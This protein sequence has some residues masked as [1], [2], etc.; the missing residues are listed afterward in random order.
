MSNNRFGIGTVTPTANLQVAGDA[1]FNTNVTVGLSSASLNRFHVQSG[2]TA[3]V[4]NQ[5]GN[6]GIGVSNPTSSLHVMGTIN[7]SSFSTAYIAVGQVSTSTILTGTISVGEISATT[8]FASNIS[9]LTQV[10]TATVFAGDGIIN[11]LSANT[12]SING[13][14]SVSS[15]V[16]ILG[17]LSLFSDV[18]IN[19]NLIL[20][21]NV[22]TDMNSERLDITNNGTGPAFKVNQIGSEPVVVI[23]QN[24][25][26]VLTIN[27]SGETIVSGN[28]SISG[29]I[30]A[31]TLIA[32]N[33][34]GLTKISAATVFAGNASISGT[35]STGTLI[36]TNISGLT[37]ISAATVF[38]GNASISGTISA[39]T[40]IAS[41]ISGLTR[42][43]TATVFAGN[44]SVSGTISTGTLI[45]SN[46][47]GLT[48]VSTATV[49][50]GTI[51]AGTLIASNISGLTQVSTAT[52]FAGTISAGTLIASNIS[53][54]TR[55][56]ATTVFAGNIS[57]SGNSNM[58]AGTLFVDGSAGNV[59]IGTT[60]PTA[61]LHVEV[62]ALS[63]GGIDTA[64]QTVLKLIWKEGVQ[65]LG[66]GEGTK[67]ALSHI[68][69]D[70]TEYEG[71]HIASFK[72]VGADDA[73]SSTSLVFSTRANT[74]AGFNATE[75]LRIT[76]S[77]NIGI[78]TSTPTAPLNIEVPAL[79]SGGATT[80]P[81]T[82]LELRW[83]EGSTQDLGIGE[84]TKIKMSFFDDSD[85]QT[86][87]GAYITTYKE[88][89]S[90]DNSSTSLIFGTRANADPGFDATEKLRVTS[91]GN[92]GIGTSNPS[93]VLHIFS[94]VTGQDTN[95]LVES[96]NVATLTLKGDRNNTNIATVEQ[97]GALINL[98][99][100]GG[101]GYRFVVSTVQT[102]NTIAD[103]TSFTGTSSNSM[104]FGSLSSG[105]RLHF[106]VNSNVNMTIVDT[107][108]VGIGTVT[109]T[110]PLHVNVPAVSTGG[111]A[112]TPQTALKLMWKEGD[113]NLGTGEGT[114]IALSHKLFDD[115]EYEGAYIASFK[116]DSGDTDSSTSLVF[117]TRL[118]DANAT[119][120]ATERLRITSTGRV[121]IGSTTPT[122]GLLVV[123]G[124][125]SQANLTGYY[126]NSTTTITS[127]T[128]TTPSVSIYGL[129]YIWAATGFVASSDRRI[130]KDIVEI[131]DDV[132]LQAVRRLKPSMYKYVDTVSRTEEQVYGF[133]AQEVQEVLPYA[134]T[135]RTETIPDI[136]KVGILSDGGLLKLSEDCIININ[137]K[138][139]ILTKDG[140]E[141]FGTVTSVADSQNIIID[142]QID[143]FDLTE[144]QEV[145]VYGREVNDFHVL[146]KEA[147]FTV[148][149]SA[150]QELDR[151]QQLHKNKL[152]EMQTEISYQNLQIQG[153]QN[154]NAQLKA[155]LEAVL[156]HLNLT[157]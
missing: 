124:T 105:T 120:T 151:Q 11:N 35:I 115:S 81:Q 64:P 8:I 149:V 23:Q 47:S 29:T 2:S 54:L 72:E 102:A 45:A 79:S 114:K 132:A 100:D 5:N 155:K 28:V 50:A 24:T 84:G 135:E 55:I 76:S 147:V 112:T 103:G 138:L 145:F 77:G 91:S 96:A 85:Q 83:R 49:F 86:Y 144:P 140:K 113:Q 95:L 99:Q 13:G 97:G 156:A 153:L 67:I 131:N 150:I 143:N 48:Q 82:L 39:G 7:A 117:G 152:Q 89:A 16:D 32:S 75:R 68:L 110:A 63:T 71:A 90:D 69:V 14:L 148:G 19:G 122:Q 118:D 15:N 129:G 33:I 73:N 31:G 6:V 60:T 93:A 139:R 104:L 92:V 9:G 108:N 38:A 123:N 57:V 137:D 66:T 10:S 34:S 18:T 41:N 157:I 154:E 106:G 27:S 61:P 130:K 22:T 119:V 53:G 20:K 42:I 58:G 46:I 43:S 70:N 127:G 128:V 1:V 26:N 121:G 142:V 36:A 133:I 125:I 44:V 88:S 98:T 80:T 59:G 87:E 74:D 25:A 56:S 17:N 134:V 52:V 3:F 65:N 141:A 78:G 101:S 146:Q 21:G 107:G 136:Y 30:S 109:P 111:V 94:N 62:P 116:E 126:F 4:I 51:S 37:Q 12:V 40:L